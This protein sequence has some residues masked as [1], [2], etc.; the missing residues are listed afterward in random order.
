[1]AWFSWRLMNAKR[2]QPWVGLPNILSN[3]F[4]VPELLQEQA[5]PSALAQAVLHWLEMR[6]SGSPK[7][8]EL[9]EKFTSLHR[10]LRCDTASVAANAIQNIIQS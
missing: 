10:S 9:E 1:M 5:T 8:R 7:I 2:L 6:S 4:V 3:A